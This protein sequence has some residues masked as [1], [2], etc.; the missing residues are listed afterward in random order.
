[1]V[2]FKNYFMDPAMRQNFA[3]AFAETHNLNLE[4]CHRRKL[5][6]QEILGNIEDNFLAQVWV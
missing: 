3:Y 6:K 5:I 2:F 4:V 1:M